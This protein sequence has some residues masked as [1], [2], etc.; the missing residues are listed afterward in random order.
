MIKYFIAGNR[1]EFRHLM[2]IMCSIDENLEKFGSTD[3]ANEK[4]EIRMS[5]DKDVEIT[6][7]NTKF[8]DITF[9]D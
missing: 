6:L 2:E 1:N 8:K 4:I 9:E 3:K 5:D 7:R